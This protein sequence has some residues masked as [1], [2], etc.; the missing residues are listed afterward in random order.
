MS[1]RDR[2]DPDPA[3]R[4][5]PSRSTKPDATE[6]YHDLIEEISPGTLLGTRYRIIRLLGAGGMGRVYLAHDNELGIE[7]ALKLIRPELVE[8][9]QAI[10]RL[11][12]ELILA[13]KVS[14]KNV[15]RIH[16]I[17]ELNGLKYLSMT[18]VEG[19]SLKD[20]LRDS[21]P[22]PLA[23]ALSIANQICE[24]VA[25]A[26]EEGVV[27][28]DLKPSNIL[29]DREDRVYITDFG[30]ARSLDAEDQ[31]KT[32]MILGTPAY[33][34][35]E[36]ARGERAD[37]R[38]DV[39]S[40]GLI[41]YELLT[42]DLPFR[43]ADVHLF[44]T[45]TPQGLDRTLRKHQPQISRY[46]I[47]VIRRC[48]DPN[49]ERR[50]ENARAVLTDLQRKLTAG[51]SGVF[52]KWM[53]A[54]VASLL[55]LA[56]GGF[57]LWREYLQKSEKKE[58]VS[59]VATTEEAESV[60]VL[61]FINKTGNAD[62]SW[63]ENSMSDIL[64]ADLSRVPNLRVVSSDRTFQVL[65][66]MKMQSG[67]Y[68]EKNFKRVS[69]ILDAETLL[70]GTITQAGTSLRADLQMIR[71][72]RPGQ[73]V[74]FK[75]EGKRQ[76]DLIGMISQIA[77]QVQ[78]RLNPD[79]KSMAP[80]LKD[81][82]VSISARKHYQ[83]GVDLLR[84]GEFEKASE[85][86]K[87]SIQ[88]APGF[89]TA[90]LRLSEAYENMDQIDPA[91]ATL[92]KAMELPESGDEKVAYMIRAKHS[93]LQGDL[94]AAVKTYQSLTKQFPNDADGLF[95]LAL[96][97]EE[98][99]DLKN[100]ASN[101]QRVIALD[102]NHSEAHFHMG[103]DTI[104]MGEA[105]KGISQNLVK[106]LSIHTQMNNEYGKAE[107]LNAMGVGYERLG[108]Y[109]DAIRYYNDSVEIKEKIGNRKG[110]AKSM[111]NIAKIHL[112]RGDFSKA[113]EILGQTLKLFE[114]M[115]DQPGVADITNMFGVLNEDQGNYP[116]ALKVL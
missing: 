87:Q 5:A 25:A 2:P 13:R 51:T 48:L 64:I 99:G 93:L 107:V 22:L 45:V 10:D 6:T 38:S 95:Q 66:D 27:H 52:P 53:W 35:P 86:L 114:E 56:A 26:H 98:K 74:F 39:Y 46:L 78:N 115:N 55:I 1:R 58:A 57:F 9:D 96:F 90:Y 23:R 41:L 28:R 75:A 67:S 49:A 81:P 111:T 69:E 72:D 11:R 44:R 109:E 73:P 42:G 16:D 3:E 65:Q 18:Y 80:P 97:Y 100:A 20:V 104:L 32:G 33:L 24:A 101:L 36:Q 85:K 70:Y 79:F 17:G 105:E 83:Q 40:I 68:S 43:H 37:A 34:S 31:T 14:H 21:H 60:I 82:A 113:E 61:P 77:T 103:K 102:P 8:N 4:S 71:I 50:Y 54:L 19:N 108:R 88:E 110:A 89:A 30:I 63:I 106:A 94:D 15:I 62:L 12:K 116:E 84:M 92:Q 76:E 91:I 59:N 29:M 112:F 7:V 47:D